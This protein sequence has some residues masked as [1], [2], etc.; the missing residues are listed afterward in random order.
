MN[1]RRILH[2]VQIRFADE[3][4]RRELFRREGARIGLGCRR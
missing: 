3:Y 1:L 2:E 4:R